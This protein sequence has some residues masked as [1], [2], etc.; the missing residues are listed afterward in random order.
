MSLFL[1]TR[2]DDGSVEYTAVNGEN[3]YDASMN[4]LGTDIIHQ[5]V[6]M[7]RS[8]SVLGHNDRIANN[9]NSKAASSDMEEP[10]LS[11]IGKAHVSYSKPKIDG[12]PAAPDKLKGSSIPLFVGDVLLIMLPVAF[13]GMLARLCEALEVC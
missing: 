2:T 10:S 13:M 4:R 6:E 7:G 12:W 3:T 5:D 1:S 9:S 11:S 8:R